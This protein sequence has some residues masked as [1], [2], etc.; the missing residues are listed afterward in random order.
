MS[1]NVVDHVALCYEH[2]RY[3]ND[4]EH[5]DICMKNKRILF[6]ESRLSVAREALEFY[7][8]VENWHRYFNRKRVYVHTDM[9]ESFAVMDYGKRAMSALDKM[10]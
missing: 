4:D 3:Y 5:C 1:D 6:L 8:N 2:D 7:G 10:K 9:P